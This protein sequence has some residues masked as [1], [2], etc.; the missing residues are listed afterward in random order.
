MPYKECDYLTTPTDEAILWRYMDF[1]KFVSLL[2]KQALFFASITSLEDPFE[3]SL[4]V[5][6]MNVR[7]DLGLRAASGQLRSDN[8]EELRRMKKEGNY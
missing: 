6:N 5:A 7:K 8:P 2:D 1:T 3:G 4:P